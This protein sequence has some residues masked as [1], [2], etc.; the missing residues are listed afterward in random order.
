MEKKKGFLAEQWY[1]YRRKKSIWGIAF[2]FVFTALLIAMLFPESR[3]VVSATIIRYS[4]FQPK[5]SA[6]VIYLKEA[7]MDWYLEDMK[8]NR[9]AFSELK[10][11]P[12]F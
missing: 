6:E 4:M 8:G 1:K 10:G 12:I 2:D 7:Q 5:E 9:I 3:K 11:Q